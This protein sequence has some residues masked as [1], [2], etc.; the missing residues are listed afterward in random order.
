LRDI[1]PPGSGDKAAGFDN[2]EKGPGLRD[3]HAI[4]LHILILSANLMHFSGFYNRLKRTSSPRD[5]TF[6]VNRACGDGVLCN[7]RARDKV[8]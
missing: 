1:Q 8:I 5:L 4:S 3:V 2:G 7:N 6:G